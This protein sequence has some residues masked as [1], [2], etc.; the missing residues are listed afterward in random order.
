MML[1]AIKVSCEKSASSLF[2]VESEMLVTELHALLLVLL[3]LIVV[4][5]PGT[6]GD[7]EELLDDDGCAF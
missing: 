2:V 7:P 1:D 3:L 5:D 6:Q 4:P